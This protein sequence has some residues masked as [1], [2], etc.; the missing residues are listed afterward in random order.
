M[1]HR[2]RAITS[3]PRDDGHVPFARDFAG[4]TRGITRWASRAS[5]L[6]GQVSNPVCAVLGNLLAG[7]S[8][9]VRRGLAAEIALGSARSRISRA[10]LHYKQ[11]RSARG[12]RSRWPWARRG[13]SWSVDAPGELEE[14]GRGRPV[15]RGTEVAVRLSALPV[16]GAAYDFGA[17]IAAHRQNWPPICSAGSSNWAIA[18]ALTFHPGTQCTDPRRGRYIDPRPRHAWAR[19]RHAGAVERPAAAFPRGAAG[20]KGPAA[21]CDLS[22]ASRGPQSRLSAGANAPALVANRA[23]RWWAERSALPC[24]SRRCGATRVY[25]NRRHLAGR[26]RKLPIMGNDRPPARHR[27]RWHATD[28]PDDRARLLWGPTCDSLDGPSGRSPPCPATWSRATTC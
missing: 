26:W 10:V 23:A 19:G 27:A 24:G 20:R 8:P 7:G 17:K 4:K 9:G 5:S 1:C 28:R 16:A 15:P 3:W 6:R 2:T 14:T 12:P 25:L 22:T 21:R 18:R 11:P 13:A